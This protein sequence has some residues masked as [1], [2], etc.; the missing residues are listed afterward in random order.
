RVRAL[1]IISSG[2]GESSPAGQA[3]QDQMVAVARGAGLRL[4]GPNCEGVVNIRG[5][6]V[7]SFSMMFHGL[8][9]G[10]ISIVSQSGAYCGVL[11]RRLHR[12]GAGPAKVISS[13]NEADLKA[14]DYLE[15]L[16]GDPETSVIGA[17]LEGI[18]E[19]R[20]FA[21]RIGEIASRKPL[22]INKT[23]RTEVGRRQ[24]ASHTGALAG[25]DRVIDALL[26]QR[27]VVRTHHLDQMVDA[28]LTLA[29]QPPLTGMR[30][31]ILSS[32][33]GMAVELSDLLTE[34]GFSIPPLAPVTEEALRA[35]IPAFGTVTNPVDFTGALIGSPAG[36]GECLQA[37]LTDPGIDAVI[38]VITA[39]R[40][41]AFSGVVLEARQRTKKPLLVCWTAGTEVAGP[42]LERLVS[43]EMAVYESPLRAVQGLEALARH[44]RFRLGADFMDPQR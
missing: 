12:G 8:R 17:H 35:H 4:V 9:A 42:A 20:R 31:A 29:S 37:V 18:W 32:A 41:P 34:A 13:G 40:D 16:A 43:A 38:L 3:Q 27:A 5:G 25:N 22:V 30:V 1:V 14:V 28:L 24:T 11:A 7:L 10:P 36:V 19:P 21:D 26:R 44:W 33:G 23:G 15:Y 6:L 39:V 2:F